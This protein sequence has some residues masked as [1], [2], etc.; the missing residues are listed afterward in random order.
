M[1]REVF[2][3]ILVMLLVAGVAA[4]PLAELLISQAVIFCDKSEEIGIPVPDII[5]QTHHL[6]VVASST[7]PWMWWILGGL[8][9]PILIFG[10]I[11]LHLKLQKQR[12]L[13]KRRVV[14]IA[15]LED[16]IQKIEALKA[17]KK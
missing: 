2:L 14:L 11:I 9:T 12:R 6:A 15:K 8:L 3:W 10:N 4:K 17:N 7:D 16:A 13:L 5:N 1:G